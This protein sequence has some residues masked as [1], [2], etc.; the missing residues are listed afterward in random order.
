MDDN[1]ISVSVNELETLCELYF[2]GVLS[3]EEERLL[4]KLLSVYPYRGGVIDEAVFVLGIERIGRKNAALSGEFCNRKSARRYD[5]GK[6]SVL[7]AIKK[8]FSTVAA[9]VLIM[10]TV[11]FC[12]SYIS[13]PVDA[14][15]CYAYINGKEIVDKDLAMEIAMK[16]YSESMAFLRQMEAMEAEHMKRVREAV[17]ESEKTAHILKE[18]NNNN[19]K[20]NSL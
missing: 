10:F 7:V 1:K 14:T 11:S 3:R 13:S 12:W 18:I 6:V 19:Y 15:E 5:Y 2:E 9:A 4:S 8:I 16:D 17:D 20:N